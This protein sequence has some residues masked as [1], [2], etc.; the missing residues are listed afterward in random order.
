MAMVI[1]GQEPFPHPVF[2]GQF[3]EVAGFL[4]GAPALEG[5]IG[6]DGGD[7]Q[8]G[9][10]EDGDFGG[11]AQAARQFQEVFLFLVRILEIW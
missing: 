2:Q 8:G 9:V 4:S 10:L 6:A 7:G 5:G 3:G 11:G 1:D